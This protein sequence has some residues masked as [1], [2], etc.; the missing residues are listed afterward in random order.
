MGNKIKA[1][2]SSVRRRL[3]LPKEQKEQVMRNLADA[4]EQRRAQGMTDAE[5]LRELGAPRQTAEKWNEHFKEFAY[6]K[7]PWRFVFL[8]AGGFAAL[9][10]LGLLAARLLLLLLLNQTTE[11]GA[12]GIIGGADGPTAIFVTTS[13]GFSPFVYVMILLVGILG[14]LRLCRCK[15]K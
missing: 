11:A 15:Q 6:R 8:L 1:Y 13:V 10:L 14:Y 3:N 4:I 2:L 12:V 7:S 9:E 5:I